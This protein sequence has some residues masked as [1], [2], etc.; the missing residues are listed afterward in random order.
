MGALAALSPHADLRGS[1]ARMAEPPGE[2]APVAG[3]VP[4]IHAEYHVIMPAEVLPAQ[5]AGTVADPAG[6]FPEVILP[7]SVTD[8]HVKL[9]GFEPAAS[10]PPAQ[11]SAKLNYSLERTAGIEPAAF[12]LEG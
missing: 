5:T 11:R 12:S 6:T 3:A 4:I 9:A 10:A 1:H 2:P 7:G 8:S